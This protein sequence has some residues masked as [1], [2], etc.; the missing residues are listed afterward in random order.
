VRGQGNADDFVGHIGGDDFVV[1][2][3]PDRVRP[4][5]ET[6]IARFDETAPLFYD[7]AT[8]ARGFIS[9]E[10]RQ[11]RPTEF[12]LVSITITVVS[13]ARRPF[14]HPGDVAQRSVEGKKRGKLIPG[15]VYLIEE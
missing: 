11:G 8:R 1:I 14:R 7:A 6:A 3:T 10:D 15:S 2:S 13:S 4:I 5:C 9:G 12:P